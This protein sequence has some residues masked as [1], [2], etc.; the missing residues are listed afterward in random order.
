MAPPLTNNDGYSPPCPKCTA[1]NGAHSMRCPTI[2]LPANWATMT[3]AE[4]YGN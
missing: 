2:N 4:R 1:A 3:E